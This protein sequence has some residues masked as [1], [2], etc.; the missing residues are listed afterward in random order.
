MAIQ[1]GDIIYAS[2]INAALNG[3]APS[4]H[5][6][7]RGTSI[8]ALAGGTDATAGFSQANFTQTEKTKLGNIGNTISTSRTG[9]GG[10]TGW[11]TFNF[12]NTFVETGIYLFRW[13]PN[14]AVSGT[15]MVGEGSTV[16]RGTGYYYLPIVKGTSNS[17][18]QCTMQIFSSQVTIRVPSDSVRSD[19]TYAAPILYRLL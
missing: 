10:T 4:S 5:V 6:G 11:L 16:I 8:H 17:L 7:A 2:E 18:A 14:L 15:F 3:K 19:D 9:S 1:A 13:S 12:N